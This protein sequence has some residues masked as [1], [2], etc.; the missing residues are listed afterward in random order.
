VG[1]EK[2]EL[3]EPLRHLSS[4]SPTFTL[5]LTRPD[6]AIKGL[7]YTTILKSIYFSLIFISQFKNGAMA[8]LND[9]LQHYLCDMLVSPSIN[10][11]ER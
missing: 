6:Q 3:V 2:E 1:G 11:K 7:A 10:D 5:S 9:K 4:C 8:A